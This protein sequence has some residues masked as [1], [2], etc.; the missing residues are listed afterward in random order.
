MSV[1]KKAV[2]P[3]VVL[4]IAGAS[5]WGYAKVKS[6]NKQ[7]VNQYRIAEVKKD[8]VKKTVSATGVLKAWTT[9]D[10]KS[11]AGGRIDK[12]AVEEGTVV[13]KGDLIALIDPSDTLLTY[14]QA[15]ADIAANRAKVDETGKSVMMQKQQTK[16]S[17]QS[18][19]VGIQSAQASAAASK[20]RYDSAKAQAESAKELS[21]A[22]ISNAT[23]TLAAEQAR[24]DQLVESA[25]PRLL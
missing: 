3:L 7:E 23:S 15:K 5:Y 13:K 18:A 6:A 11:R 2:G 21:D 19:Q 8:L 10:I 9:V 12:L 17:I 14:N 4:A 1:V 24:L 16:V 20:A 22:A 25:S